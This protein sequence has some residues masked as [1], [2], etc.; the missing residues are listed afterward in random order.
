VVC[1]RL[2]YREVSV[3]EGHIGEKRTEV[4]GEVVVEH[5]D[6]NVVGVPH[7]LEVEHVAFR[8]LRSA[9]GDL[10][11]GDELLDTQRQLGRPEP[12]PGDIDTETVPL[13][14]P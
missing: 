5:H 11:I 6:R 7:L 2:L 3:V 13:L 1:Q 4:K 14:H 12:A 10:C 9:M 8:E